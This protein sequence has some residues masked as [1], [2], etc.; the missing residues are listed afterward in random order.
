MQIVEGTYPRLS[1]FSGHPSS[2]GEVP[3]EVWHYEV[4]C[5]LKEGQRSRQIISEAMRRSV[6]GSAAMTL[7]YL[8]AGATVEDILN[9]MET[10]MVTRKRVKAVR[11]VLYS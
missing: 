7:I 5:L 6:R 2:K 11:T 9:H 4:R 1:A 10:H 8:G 3:F